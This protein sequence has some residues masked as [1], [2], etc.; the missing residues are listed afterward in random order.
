MSSWKEKVIVSWLAV[1]SIKNAKSDQSTAER[2]GNES[3]GKIAI[4]I[5][6]N[7]NNNNN[8]NLRGKFVNRQ[9][10]SIKA[11]VGEKVQLVSESETGK[12]VQ[13]IIETTM[14]GDVPKLFN[15]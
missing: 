7:N 11:H 9:I 1:G 13:N 6:K 10:L 2:G 8:S 3:V 12:T 5:N 15:L 4:Y 14:A